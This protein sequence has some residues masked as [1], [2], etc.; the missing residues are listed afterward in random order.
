MQR[1]QGET[2][3]EKVSEKERQCGVFA[4]PTTD[5]VLKEIQED[6]LQK[7]RGFL[8]DTPGCGVGKRDGGKWLWTG[9]YP[10]Q[11]SELPEDPSDMERIQTHERHQRIPV[12]GPRT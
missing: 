5:Q 6:P 1:T 7:F 11:S 2:E 9:G 12:I 3:Q 10:I 8:R 4:S